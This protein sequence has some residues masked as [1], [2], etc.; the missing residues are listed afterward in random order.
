MRIGVSSYWFNRGQ[1]TVG[2]HLRSA[3]DELGHGT[4]VLARPAKETAAKPA[5][6]SH[7]DIWDQPGVTTASQYEIPLGEMLRWSKDNAIEVAFFD[8]NYQF[9]EIAQLRASGVKTIG[10]FV[11]EQFREEHVEPAINAFDVI[12]SV[13]SCERERYARL[14]FH[15][16][17]VRW[18]IHPELLDPA[19]GRGHPDDTVR[20]FFP[21]G[22]MTKRKPLEPVIEA[23]TATKDPR[24]RLILKAQVQ[25][26]IKRVRKLI[27]RDRR[28]EVIVDDLPYE[29]HMALFASSDVVLAPSR[30][31]GL[32]LHLYEAMGLGIPV[33]TNDNPPMNEVIRN[34]ENGLL[35]R[36][37]EMAERAP[38][39]IRAYD[40]DVAALTAA[41]ERTADPAEL[42]RLKAG[43]VASR[44]RLAWSN[45]L[46]DLGDLLESVA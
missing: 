36:G 38:S 24:L 22:Y 19:L 39:G 29:E 27:G 4:F 41:I 3:L 35:V 10:R 18:G 7:D 16:P 45:T 30:W 34:G 31:E 5:H 1:A 20:L 12:Y 32:G 26:K 6:I 13:I 33:I 9:D 17:M 28:V 23:F 25:K 40:P 11:W 44:E 46:T 2:R 42:G 21:G 14:G 37:I 8:Q 15:S 43:A